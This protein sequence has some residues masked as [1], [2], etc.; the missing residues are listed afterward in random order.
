MTLPHL[1]QR[2][3]AD[4]DGEP[5]EELLEDDKA[6]NIVRW[7]DTSV[8][9]ADSLTKKM[10]ATNLWP[11]MK[12]NLSLTPTPESIITKMRKQKARKKTIEPDP[13]DGV[14][15]EDTVCMPNDETW[16]KFQ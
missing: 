12:G 6:N 2:L 16:S 15:V 9:I 10:K 8:M 1:R 7:I 3:W 13:E 4:I 5:Y 14:Q 11:A